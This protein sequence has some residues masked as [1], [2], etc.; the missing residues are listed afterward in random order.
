[1][2]MHKFGIQPK[3]TS[4]AASAMVYAKNDTVFPRK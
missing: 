2:A 3:A 1:M 4:Q